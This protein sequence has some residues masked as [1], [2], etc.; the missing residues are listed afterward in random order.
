MATMKIMQQSAIMSSARQHQ[1]VTVVKLVLHY[2]CSCHSE[3]F[4][5]LL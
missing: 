1:L 4:M 3:T 2:E 5:L